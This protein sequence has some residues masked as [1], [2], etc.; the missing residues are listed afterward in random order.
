MRPDRTA[1]VFE[2]DRLSYGELN[3]RAN[4]LARLLRRRG[5][6]GGAAVGVCLERSLDMIVALLGVQKAGAAYVPMDPRFPADRLQFM[7]ADSGIRALIAS[8]ESVARFNLPAGVEVIDLVAEAEA[9]DMLDASDL[10]SNA[11]PEDIAYIIYT[12][13]STGRPNGVTVSHGALANFLGAMRRSAWAARQRCRR[14]G[15][16]DIVRYRCSGTLSA[17]DCWRPNPIGVA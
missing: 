13:G 8:E 4:Q 6:T 5:V 3:R 9:L 17:A 1:V 15:D 14:R 12:S 7:L 11:A 2:G 10:A 16:D